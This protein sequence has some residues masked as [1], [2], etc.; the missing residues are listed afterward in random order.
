MNYN[1]DRYRRRSIRLKG[2]D[3]SKPGYYHVTI[4]SQDREC[5]FGEIIDRKM[6]LN[7]IG[8]II[9]M[10]WRNLSVKYPR[11]GNNDY[12]IMP[13]H[14][15]R[16]IHIQRRGGVAPPVD[17]KSPGNP[18]AGTAPLHK[19]P[20]LGQIVGF[21]KYITTKLVNTMYETPGK[22]LWQ[23]GFFD[24]ILRNETDVYEIRTYI[25]N[26]PRNWIDDEYNPENEN[27]TT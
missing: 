8:E 4:C 15:H 3:Y 14:L 27:I 13:N 7:E 10:Q 19:T 12:V 1:P 6:T 17:G 5:L 18:G 26:N 21:L 9:D 2:H 22:K 11:I 24:Q 25:K 20:N 16:I 23:R